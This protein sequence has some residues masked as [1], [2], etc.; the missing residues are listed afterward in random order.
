[1]S[2]VTPD[3]RIARPS[4]SSISVESI[5]AELDKRLDHCRKVIAEVSKLGD[6]AQTGMDAG[7]R[8]SWESHRS[9]QFSDEQ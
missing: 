9:S 1:V 8:P 4:F 5:E 3:I 7:A 6:V 2:T